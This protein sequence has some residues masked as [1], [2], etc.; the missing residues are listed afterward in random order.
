MLF[1]LDLAVIEVGK[2]Y[3]SGIITWREYSNQY[4]HLLYLAYY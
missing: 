3:K 4:D 1:N 2:M